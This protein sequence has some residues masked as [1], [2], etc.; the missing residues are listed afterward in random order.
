MRSYDSSLTTVSI[1]RSSFLLAFIVNLYSSLSL[2]DLYRLLQ[3]LLFQTRVN[4]HH[5]R[6]ARKW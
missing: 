5:I 6:D 3:Q 1:Y 4:F 2:S